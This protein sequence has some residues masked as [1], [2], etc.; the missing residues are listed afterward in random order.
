MRASDLSASLCLPFALVLGGIAL[1]PTTV[2]AQDQD[3]RIDRFLPPPT[4][5]DGLAMPAASTIGHLNPSFGLVIDYAHQPLVAR[6]TASDYTAAIVSH[7]VLFN[8]LAA[9]GILDFLEFHLRIPV[10]F[11]DGDQPTLA[12]TTFDDPDPATISDPAI[13]GSVRI[14]GEEDDVF[15]LGATV[16]AFIP[17]AGGA[18]SHATDQE[19]SMR[20]L[21]LADIA[22]SILNIEIMAGVN[23]RPER[24]LGNDS[25]RSFTELNIG[26]GGRF[27]ALGDAGDL[28]IEFILSTGL[29]D[30]LVFQGTGT[31]LEMILGGRFRTDIGLAIEAGL[32]LGFLR[33]PGTPAVR[34]FAGVR[35]DSPAPPP[36][37]A[38]ADGI[39][40]EADACPDQAEDLDRFQDDD[41]CPDLDND[42]DGVPDTEDGCV[43]EPEDV[44]GYA[45][46]D[47]CPELD[48][49]EDGFN[50][51][52][53]ECPRVPGNARSAGCPTTIRV[54][55]SDI[56]LIRTID[57]TSGTSQLAATNGQIL[58]EIAG[59]MTFDP[60]D[61]RWQI[62][63]RPAAGRRGSDD[64]MAQERADAIV[65][66]LVSRGVDPA[67]LEA[68]VG[69]A[70]DDEFIVVRTLAGE[71]AAPD[72]E[73][74]AD[75]AGR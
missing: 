73:V 66:S 6:S 31:A 42:E 59:V 16:E 62:V 22:L 19:F 30:D 3:M 11:Q 61:V 68:V 5:H 33:A 34:I 25:Y 48:D 53:D 1:S 32:G 4:T 23:Y 64:G 47:G 24:S 46:T 14:F 52:V 21:L 75:E 18:N 37:D 43:R 13:G 67:R 71:G 38:D 26:L 8:L 58:D 7:R 72:G 70:R 29:R 12:G 69:D 49:D 35:W 45:D 39:L 28:M 51:D 27:A 60:T 57:F 55:G 9:I 36:P 20:G 50:D 15:Q 44:D 17:L 41:G 65:R 74:E 54:S 40:D 56:E 2:R 63:V 10:V